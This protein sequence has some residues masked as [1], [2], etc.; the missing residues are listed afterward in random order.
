MG[1]ACG[2]HHQCESGICADSVCCNAA[3]GG[4]CE[5]C[6]VPWN[7]GRCIPVTGTPYGGRTPCVGVGACVG[8]CDGFNRGFC[9]FPSPATQCAAAF[10]SDGV[11]VPASRCDGRGFCARP[12]QNPCG[13]YACGEEDCKTS[14]QMSSDCAFGFSCDSGQCVVPPPPLPASSFEGISARGAGG[15]GAAG[16][17]GSDAPLWLS[18]LTVMALLG[19][20]RH[21]QV[22]VRRRGSEKK[23]RP[24]MTPG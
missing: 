9:T 19:L 7:E 10:C 18:I 12:E 13:S 1:S 8:Y 22:Q 11:S 3:C 24:A 6:N 5:A 14:C 15:C 21:R 17:L 16:S 4:Q 20:R 23:Q 2:G